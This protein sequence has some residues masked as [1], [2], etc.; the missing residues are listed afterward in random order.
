[1]HNSS[2]P[3]INELQKARIRLLMHW[4]IFAPFILQLEL[5]EVDWCDTAA[6]D[7]RHF[8]YNREFVKKLD[9]EQ[10][11][12]LTAHE[13][14]HCCLDHIFRRGHRDPDIWNCAIDYIVNYSLVNT[15]DRDGKSI[16]RMIEKVPPVDKSLYDPAY[17]DEFSAEELYALLEKD[18]TKIQF[19]VIG[20]DGKSTM[21][22]RRPLDMHLEPSD[23][24]GGDKQQT[25]GT[26]GPPRPTQEQIEATRD[27]I[28]ATLI[29]AVQQPNLDP[30][31]VPAG[32]LRLLNRLLEPKLNWREMLDN[33]LRSSLKH[34]YTYTRLSR[35]F[36]TTGLVLPGQ[37]NQDKVTAVA[38]LDGSGS[39]TIEMVT[40]FLSECKGIMDTFADY[41]LTVATFDTKIYNV[42]VYTPDNADEILSYEFYGGGG[43]QPLCCW[44]YLKEHDIVPDKILLFTDGYVGGDW[45]DPDYAST[46]FIVH[47]N[48][49]AKASHGLTVHY[50]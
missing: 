1:M 41:E 9:R 21:C 15:K 32:V 35:R 3:V 10:L 12:F 37:D 27:L 29:Q 50:P 23:S 26:S 46:L 19:T 25:D 8:F 5:K 33:V 16:G 17:T 48:P 34:D 4:P 11:M 6:T 36:W 18:A 47:S 13:I 2:D 30:G 40:E 24:E 31:K 45:G 7:G 43:T 14:L 49:S 42:V 22:C 39:T 28:K 38:F 20:A 44:D